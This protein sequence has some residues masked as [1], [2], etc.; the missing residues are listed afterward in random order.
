MMRLGDLAEAVGGWVSPVSALRSVSECVIDSR[1]AGEGSLFFALPGTRTDGHLFVRDVLERDG[2]AVVSEGD[3]GEGIVEVQDVQQALLDAAGWRRR[4]MNCSVVAITGS[5]GKTTTRRLLTAALKGKYAVHS[6]SGNLNNHI[7]LP[8]VILNAPEEEPDVMVLEAGMN[9]S[10]E[11]SILGAVARPTHCL[12]TNIGRAHMEFF[13]SLED[14]ARAKAELISATLPGGVCVIPTEQEILVEAAVDAGL[15]I[16]FF[17]PGGDVWTEMDREGRCTV[18]PWKL[19]LEMRL[20]GKH[21]CTNASAALLMA[22]ILGIPPDEAARSMSAVEPAT[23]RG[24]RVKTGKF[25]I[26][27]ESYNAN[28]DSTLACLETLSSTPGKRVAVL[29]DMRELGENGP[30]FHR[31]VLRKADSIGLELMILTGPIYASVSSEARKTPVLLAADW[32][33]ALELFLREVSGECTVLVKGS[34]S[35]KLGE[36]VRALEEGE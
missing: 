19:P 7:G 8:L 2:M 23:G 33:E 3:R 32:R 28:P 6:A 11:L 21:H 16:G 15:S 9:H 1:K 5:S 27:D 20:R 18:M 12:V 13:D 29:G 17:G 31:E 36:L 26:L 34:N 25:L 14:V 35:L 30:S 10:G 24:R 22:R 4:T